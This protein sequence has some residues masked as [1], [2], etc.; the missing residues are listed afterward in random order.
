MRE[1]IN[2][3]LLTDSTTS[4]VDDSPRNWSAKKKKNVLI[5]VSATGIIGSIGNS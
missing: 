2:Y 4:L 1:T 5:L 3:E